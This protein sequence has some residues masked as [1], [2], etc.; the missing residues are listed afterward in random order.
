MSDNSDDSDNSD[1]SDDSD[2]SD[3][4]DNSDMSDNS[5]DA[6]NYGE[7]ESSAWSELTVRCYTIKA[8]SKL[9]DGLLAFM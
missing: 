2:N 8:A 7:S 3:N 5:D 6:I 9:A 4:S 1:N